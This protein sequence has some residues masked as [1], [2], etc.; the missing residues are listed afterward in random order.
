VT[1]KKDNQWNE[2]EAALPWLGSETRT[3]KGF[4]RKMGEFEGATWERTTQDTIYRKEE[5]RFIL[6]PMD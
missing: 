1:H 2:R 3:W 5:E 4:Y 6:L